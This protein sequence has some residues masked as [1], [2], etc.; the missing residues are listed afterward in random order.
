MTTTPNPEIDRARAK[1]RRETE[2]WLIAHQQIAILLDPD[3]GLIEWEDLPGLTE[4]EFNLVLAHF[5][6]FAQRTQKSVDDWDE[7]TKANERRWTQIWAEAT[8]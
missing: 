6:G 1:K 3:N 4:G 2:L 8:T 5:A 7:A